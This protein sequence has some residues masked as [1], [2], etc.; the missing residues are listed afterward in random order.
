VLFR[1]RADA[2]SVRFIVSTLY[3][4]KILMQADPDYEK[5]LKALPLVEMRR[6]L[7]GDWSI[8]PAGGKLYKKA[9]FKVVDAAPADLSNIVRGWDLAATEEKD[10][11]KKT[12]PDFTAT[13]KVGKLPDGRY[14]IMDAQ[15]MRESPLMVEHAVTNT[16]SQ[17]MQK[18]SIYMEQEPGSAGVNNISHYARLL[19]GYHFKGIRSTGSKV[20]RSRPVSSQAE[21]GNIL[22]LRAPWND[23]FLDE[24]EAFPDE[25]V[26]DDYCDALSLAMGQLF[27][28]KHI[29][30]MVVD[31]TPEDAISESELTDV[32]RIY[33]A[34]LNTEFY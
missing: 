17:D 25:R 27:G 26:H 30:G 13:V 32:E 10:D 31:D 34:F 21:A 8:R 29:G 3:D 5:N 6:L 23:A 2:T 7:Y 20:D 9:W 12:G 24:L 16:A 1:S 22:I 28:P 33:A 19:A 4:N 15:R 14:I 18:V 11:S